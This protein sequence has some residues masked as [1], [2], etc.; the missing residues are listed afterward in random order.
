ME[1]PP[2]WR[3]ID[4]PGLKV[5]FQFEHRDLWIGAFWRKTEVAIHLYIGF[6]P[7]VSLHVT[8]ARPRLKGET[9]KGINQCED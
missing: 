7:C 5:Q 6:V 3:L 1:N 2:H 9:N 8:W 4:L